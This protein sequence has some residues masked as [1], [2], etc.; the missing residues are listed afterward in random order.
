MLLSFNHWLAWSFI[1]LIGNFWKVRFLGRNYWLLR[2]VVNKDICSAP[3][4]EFENIT[5]IRVLHYG[6]QFYKTTQTP[7][8]YTC[9]FKRNENQIRKKKYDCKPWLNKQIKWNQKEVTI[10][11]AFHMAK[12]MTSIRSIQSKGLFTY[13]SATKREDV[14]MRHLVTQIGSPWWSGITGDPNLGVI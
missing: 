7:F 8:A 9:N 14:L 3:E 4:S 6:T 10:S 1:P 12:K 11:D 2:K 13:F 5:K